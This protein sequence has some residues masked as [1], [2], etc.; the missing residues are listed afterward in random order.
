MSHY[1]LASVWLGT[2]IK[3]K[4]KE[5]EKEPWS[6]VLYIK[7]VGCAHSTDGEVEAGLSGFIVK[8]SQRWE[9]AMQR[10]LPFCPGMF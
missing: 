9:K 3:A 7:E 2:V 4:L 6:H 8:H 10:H 5:K 1:I